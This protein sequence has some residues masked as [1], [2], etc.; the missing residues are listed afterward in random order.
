MAIPAVTSLVLAPETAP[1]GRRR[2]RQTAERILDAAEA[3]F[4]ERGFAGT[5]LRDVASRVG[6]QNPSLYNHFDSKES[7]YA[8]VLERGI[9]PVLETLSAFVERADRDGPATRDL[10][11]RVL[12]LLGAR[13]EL[14]RLLQHEM[15]S[16]GQH[17]TDMLREWIEPVFARSF[18][19]I[20]ANPGAARWR[21]DQLPLLILAFYN[22]VIG[23]FGVAPLYAQLTGDDPL[24]KDALA[25]QTEFFADLVERLLGESG[26]DP[27]PT[28]P[29]D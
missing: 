13:P 19:L 14:A 26:A 24:S 16:G 1:K 7:L 29:T 12:A 9:R 8:A 10:A 5:T 17:L 6:I 18:E 11:E 28:D 20:E 4:A 2:G 23:Y 22:V 15:L 27:S 21:P 3:S 25:R